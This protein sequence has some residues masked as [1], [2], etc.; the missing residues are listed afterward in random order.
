MPTFIK[1]HTTGRFSRERLVNI[2]HIVYMNPNPYIENDE[3]K[4]GTGIQT[5][6]AEFGYT[7]FKESFEEVEKMIN[8]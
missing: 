6:L 8:G 4:S 2:N 1:L 5:V 7:V 3:Q